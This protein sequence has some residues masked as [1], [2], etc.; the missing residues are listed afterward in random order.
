MTTPPDPAAPPAAPAAPTADVDARLGRIETTLAA[1][2]GQLHP[3]AQ[4]HTERRLERPQRIEEQ[5][6]AALRQAEADRQAQADK[7]DLAKFRE[8]TTKAL[9][10]LRETKPGQAVA[11]P[12]EKL[13][14]WA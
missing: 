9:K 5:V 12:V 3:A 2:S 10:E 6:E 8:D 11:R 1:L 14:G 13:M 7:A 4:A